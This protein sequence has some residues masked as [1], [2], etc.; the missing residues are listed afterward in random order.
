MDFLKKHYEKILLGVMLVGLIGVLVFMFFY[1]AS[2]KSDMQEKSSSLV[3]LPARPLA[4]VA[5]TNEDTAIQ[6]LKSPYKLDFENTNLLLNPQ[7]WVRAM[8]G[9]LAPKATKTGLQMAAVTNISPLY[10]I[11][12]LESTAT[13]ELGARYVIRAE[14][15]AAPLI[16]N[17]RPMPHYVSLGDKANDAFQ[18]LHV[19]GPPEN[20]ESL[21]LKLTDSGEVVNISK[22]KPYKHVDGYSADIRYDPERKIFHGS[23]IGGK[24]TVGGVDYTV[25]EVGPNEVIFMDQSNQKKTSLPFSP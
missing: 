1:I 7:S 17:R 19:K 14:R 3:N 21:E 4:P 11:I 12:S 20:P 10:F 15:Q 23:R 9:T 8:D 25:V 6:R 5:M 2:Q 18:L 16:K 22:E 13:N 24:I